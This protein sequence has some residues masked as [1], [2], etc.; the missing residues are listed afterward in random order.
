MK[1][2]DG[3]SHT[4]SD[5]QSKHKS[6][7]NIF[8]QN[9]TAET[10]GNKFEC[11]HLSG[12]E[13]MKISREDRIVSSRQHRNEDRVS[14]FNPPYPLRYIVSLVEAQR[15]FHPILSVHYRRI[16][17]IALKNAGVRLWYAL[18]SI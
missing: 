4:Y 5:S 15:N 3:F 8:D 12:T 1:E 6:I 16:A 2:N 7:D 17:T 13:T 9:E 18:A 14:L 10:F 11:M